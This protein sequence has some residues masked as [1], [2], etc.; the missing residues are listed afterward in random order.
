MNK[1][2]VKILPFFYTGFPKL[3]FEGNCGGFVSWW[4][5]NIYSFLKIIYNW[6]K[7]IIKQNTLKFKYFICL[8]AHHMTIIQHQRTCKLAWCQKGP[9]D[10]N[11]E[12]LSHCNAMIFI[13]FNCDLCAQILFRPAVCMCIHVCIH[14]HQWLKSLCH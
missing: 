5:A 1:S 7:Y 9:P 11:W 12:F 14:K 6:K 10:K 2:L 4:K 3:Q 8:P 13:H